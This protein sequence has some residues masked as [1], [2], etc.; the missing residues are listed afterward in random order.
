MTCEFS[1][2]QL[3]LIYTSVNQ[4]IARADEWREEL[5]GVKEAIDKQRTY[6]FEKTKPKAAAT[7]KGK[8]VEDSAKS[9]HHI[10]TD[11]GSAVN[12]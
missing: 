4:S 6:G 1:V 3:D 10:L 2:A 5:I 11:E 7:A 8:A 12:G 9:L